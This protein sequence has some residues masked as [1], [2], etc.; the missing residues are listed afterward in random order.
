[1]TE[2]DVDENDEHDDDP[3]WFAGQ[4]GHFDDKNNEND[5][6]KI[7]CAVQGCIARGGG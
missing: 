2:D 7:W 3:R 6:D 5:D 4:G 1:M